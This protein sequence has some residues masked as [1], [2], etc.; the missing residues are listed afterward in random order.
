MQEEYHSP[1]SSLGE[2]GRHC[3]PISPCP[4]DICQERV[5]K[6]EE[7][8]LMIREFSKNVGNS[9]CDCFCGIKSYSF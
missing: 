2:S 4:S 5:Q 8:V 7:N 9:Y 6:G 3:V 1:G